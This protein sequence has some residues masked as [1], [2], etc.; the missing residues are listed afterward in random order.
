M[1]GIW[2][3]KALPLAETKEEEETEDR[4]FMPAGLKRKP[5]Q[6]KT[7]DKNETEAGAEVTKH[8]LSINMYLN[9]PTYLVPWMIFSFP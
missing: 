8:I 1:K 5:K 4:T 9:V 7:D 6:R 3:I 2:T